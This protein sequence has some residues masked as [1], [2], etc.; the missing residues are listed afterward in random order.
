MR[1]LAGIGIAPTNRAK[2][3]WCKEKVKKYDI[4]G[5]VEDVFYS[6]YAERRICKKC[7]IEKMQKLKKEYEKT[8]KEAKRLI[9]QRILEEL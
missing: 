6:H 4:S 1:G 3:F 9:P 7:T 2:C 5:L 8:K